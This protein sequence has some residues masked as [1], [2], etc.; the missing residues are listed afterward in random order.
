MI[1]YFS[2][3][4]NSAYVAKRIAKINNEKIINL[5]EKIKEEDYACIN[6]ETSFVIVTPTYAWR[7]PRLLQKWLEK[8]E[9]MGNKNIYFVMTCGGSIGNAEKYLKKLCKKK[10]MNYSG[11]FEIV[12]P[13][14]YVALFT[15]PT[16]EEALKI[17]DK[18][19][20]KIEQTAQIIKNEEKERAKKITILDRLN[21]SIVNVLFYPI[22]VKSKKFYAKDT[23]ISCGK[24]EKVCPTKNIILE[25]KKP[26][27]DKRCV[28]CMAC[29]SHCPTGAIEYGK[30]SVGLQKYTCPKK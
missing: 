19:E 25:N 6:S 2:G 10:E 27:W 11:C 1:L 28:H 20:I 18:S 9:L 21:S 17:I 23:C 12:M 7:I 29:I 8:T 15:T 14:N 13:E 5:F 16:K 3:T 22:F 24:C 26:K 4:G 30:H